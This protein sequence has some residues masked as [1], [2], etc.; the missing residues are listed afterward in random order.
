[1]SV[2]CVRRSPWSAAFDVAT[3]LAMA[4]AKGMNQSDTSAQDRLGYKSRS[5]VSAACCVI[6][7]G[8]PGQY[9]SGV[10]DPPILYALC[11]RDLLQW[12]S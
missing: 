8:G 2:T 9:P 7:G 1:M 5:D 11:V 12:Y 6:H 10:P 4:M 3:A